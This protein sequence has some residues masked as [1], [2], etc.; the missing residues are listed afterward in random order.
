MAKLVEDIAGELALEPLLARV[1]ES[2]CILIGAD[3][4]SI[5]LYDRSRDV[6]RTAAVYH[7]PERELGAEMARGVGLAGLVL[8]TGE[9]AL[10]RYG[11]VPCA[12]L[13]ELAD[14]SVIGL[15]IRRGDELLGFFGIGVRP[16]RAFT[17]H[18][19]ELLQRFARH[20]GVAITNARRYAH[21]RR[22]TARFELI[23]RVASGL[24]AG[25]DL[26]AMLQK[27]ADAIHELLEYPNVDIPLLDPSDREVLVVQVRGGDY[28]RAI[29]GTD[30]IP[31]ARGIMGAAVR[32]RRAQLVNDVANDPRY[33]TPPGVR[34]PRAELA[35]PIKLDDEVLGVVNVESD[36]DFDEPDVAG[37]EVVADYLAVA[38]MNARLAAQARDAAVLAERH[39]LAR[40]LHDNVTQ[41]LSSINLLA[42][43]LVP[44]WRRDPDEG[45]RRVA[46]LNE[47]TRTA[48]AEM[49]ALLHELRPTERE[50]GISKGGRAYLGL[51]RLREHALPGALTRLLA[52]M[53]PESLELRLDFAGYVPQRLEHE[54][55]LFRVCQE[56]VS[57]AIRHAHAR[58]HSVVA[59]V[60]EAHAV[61]IVGDVG[62]GIPTG[63][64]PG[65]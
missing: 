14:N 55:A 39:R 36:R 9:P 31:V 24:A 63:R 56:A 32:E 54:E 10:M 23:A 45:A 28:K 4:G 52:A 49:R 17:A 65:I 8:E 46:R 47:L 48:F 51:E 1:V 30:R 21:E 19:V 18:D 42:Q 35:V 41:V 57:N 60:H 27:A 22:R 29:T 33:V 12:T 50:A 20:A 61:L 40:E 34:P 38:I 3:D 2:A 44:V 13:P 58:R 15:P 6:I 37:L 11:D 62:R 53:M 59:A 43:T 25:T 64:A 7:M 5:G 26:T 16:P